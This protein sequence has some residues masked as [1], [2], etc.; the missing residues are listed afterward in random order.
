MKKDIDTQ[1]REKTG[2][3]KAAE[4]GTFN[5]SRN[6]CA[7]KKEISQDWCGYSLSDIINF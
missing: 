2:Y 7:C 5:G 1:H 6:M 3:I 4:C